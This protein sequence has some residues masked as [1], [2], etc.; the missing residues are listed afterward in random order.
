MLW[1]ITRAIT[2]TYY[3]ET[4]QIVVVPLNKNNGQFKIGGFF[5]TPCI[6]AKVYVATR[7]GSISLATKGSFVCDVAPIR[8]RYRSAFIK[9]NLTVHNSSG[10]P[11]NHQNW[12]K[13]IDEEPQFINTDC[14]HLPERNLYLSRWVGKRVGVMFTCALASLRWQILKAPRS[15]RPNNSSFFACKNMCSRGS[16]HSNTSVW[17]RVE[18]LGPIRPEWSIVAFDAGFSYA[19]LNSRGP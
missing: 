12:V 16:R 8:S 10:F 9:P 6:S 2:S 1:P 4:E 17:N 18:G 5:C 11:E 13:S 7:F 14:C 15:M 3:S 19:I